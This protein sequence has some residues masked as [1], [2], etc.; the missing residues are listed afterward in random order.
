ME[1]FEIVPINDPIDGHEVKI[2]LTKEETKT[3]LQY[4]IT[5]LVSLG[6]VSFATS[7][8]DVNIEDLQLEET[9]K[10]N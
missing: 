7:K 3:L 9:G 1:V 4:A 5:Y 10:P 2:Y 6:A 8:G